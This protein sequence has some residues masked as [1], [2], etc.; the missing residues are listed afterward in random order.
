MDK[1]SRDSTRAT[2]T[3]SGTRP[4][5]PRRGRHTAN[6]AARTGATPAASIRSNGRGDAD[7]LPTNLWAVHSSLR[8][9][10]VDLDCLL[11]LNFANLR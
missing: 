4:Q 2:A 11:P 9:T 8:R 1:H 5:L 7:W 3:H 6:R 10:A